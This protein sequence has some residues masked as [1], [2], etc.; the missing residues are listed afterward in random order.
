MSLVNAAALL[1]VSTAGTKHT[2]ALLVSNGESEIL[3]QLKVKDAMLLAAAD[4]KYERSL[5]VTTRSPLRVDLISEKFAG[6]DAT[7]YFEP[8]VG[9]LA[10]V[11]PSPPKGLAASPSANVG[12]QTV[13][14]QFFPAKKPRVNV[15]A[16]KKTLK[17]PPAASAASLLPLPQP[18]GMPLPELSPMP[19]E[20]P[21]SPKPEQFPESRPTFML[22][23]TMPL[24]QSLLVPQPLPKSPPML[25][26]KPMPQLVSKPLPTPQTLPSPQHLKTRKSLVIQQSLPRSPPMLT[27]KP[28][29]TTQALPP[30]KLIQESL[31]MPESLPQSPPPKPAMMQ[32]SLPTLRPAGPLPRWLQVRSPNAVPTP[33]PKPPSKTSPSTAPVQPRAAAAATSAR[34]KF[35]SDAI[36]SYYDETVCVGADGVR[37]APKRKIFSTSPYFVRRRT[38]L[39]QQEAGG[40]G[41]GDKRQSILAYLL[42]K[43]QQEE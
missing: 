23:S 28:H 42:Q 30:P 24:K 33:V 25:S 16:A 14:D 37:T 6:V 11:R 40:S 21:P 22:S 32:D 10:R 38:E 41:D 19:E 4:H 43:Q 39:Q 12:D 7:C 15:P 26:L 1:D 27:P 20:N 8:R 31:L 18:M 13:I 17:L 9:P 5:A 29:P 36:R 2:C 35:F 3:L 34:P